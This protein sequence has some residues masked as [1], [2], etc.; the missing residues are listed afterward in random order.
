MKSL[1][2]F[3]GIFFVSSCKAQK[4]LPLNTLMK[5]IPVNAHVKDL[6]NELNPYIG[7]YK[8]NYQGN[9]I[10]LHITKEED[11][12]T[13]RMNK[14]FFR[15]VLSIRYTVKNSSGIILQNTQN[16]S[17]NNQS[18]FNILSI[19]VNHPYGEVTFI[20]DGTHCGIGWGDILL[21]KINSNQISWEY[22]PDSLVIDEATC[23][24]GTDK[25]V[26][27]P[28]TKDLVFTKQ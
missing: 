24:T 25:K 4:T 28:V 13:K 10:T 18:Y 1:L 20:Y 8:A 7:T 27:L 21:R 3:L 26:Y 2:I 16:M 9:E 11:R 6:N 14:N 5:D 17:L 23:P 19:G 12:P 22:R 15:D